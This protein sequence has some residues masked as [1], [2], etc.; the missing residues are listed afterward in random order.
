MK[1]AK[2]KINLR[3]RNRLI[4]LTKSGILI[5]GILMML[6]FYVKDSIGSF[7]MFLR[8]C[9]WDCLACRRSGSPVIIIYAALLIFAH[10]N[11]LKTS[12]C[13]FYSY[14]CLFPH[15]TNGTLQAGKI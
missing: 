3:E 9:P 14:S 7:G 6:S 4:T 2:E 10:E 5:L 13:I 8:K 11:C 15:D 1:D 12:L